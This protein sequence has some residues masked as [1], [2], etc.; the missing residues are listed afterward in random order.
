LFETDKSKLNDR[1]ADAEMAV[2][3]RARELFHIPGDNIEEESALDDA[4]YALHALRGVAE[5][6]ARLPA[7]AAVGKKNSHAA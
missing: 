1:I 4:L 7:G 3:Q 2:V 5:R 6:H